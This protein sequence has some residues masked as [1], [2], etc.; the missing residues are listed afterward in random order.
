MCGW[1]SALRMSAGCPVRGKGDIEDFDVRIVDQRIRR[2]M[3]RRNIPAL[4]NG[5]SLFPRARRDG[6]DREARFLVGRQMALRHDHAGT[7]AAD[8]DIPNPHL[9]IRRKTLG[10]A[11]NDLPFDMFVHRPSASPA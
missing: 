9:R 3:H 10:F 11:H 6:D 4:C 5:R 1:A 2:V 7:D 8:P